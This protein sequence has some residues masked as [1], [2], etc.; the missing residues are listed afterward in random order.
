MRAVVALL[1]CGTL[2][3]AGKGRKAA[4]EPEPEPEP[5]VEPEPAAVPEPTAL[6]SA[7]LP[8]EIGDLPHGLANLSAQGCNA[9]HFAAHES[10]SSSTH[11]TGHASS[12]FVAAVADLGTPACTVCHLPIASQQPDLLVF[13]ADDINRPVGRI[14]PSWNATLRTE[15]VTCAAC[16]VRDGLVIGA[17]PATGAAPHPIGWSPELRDSKICATCHQ[18]TWP[19]ANEPLYDT[20]GE[21]ERSPQAAAGISC[22]D[23][24]MGP[25]ASASQRRANHAF[26]ARAGR[27]VSVLIDMSPEKI[28]R[29]D[30]AITA[31]IRLQ[32]TGAG[33][34][35]P[36]GSPFRGIRVEIYLESGRGEKAIRAAAIQFDLARTLEDEA[37]WSTV[38]DTRLAPGEERRIDWE[39]TLDHDAPVGPWFLV[40]TATE[41]VLGEVVGVPVVERRIP[42]RVE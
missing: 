30:N 7:P 12:R 31:V 37:P 8:V 26:S 3:H 9:C 18:L 27:G 22:Q 23:C 34:A 42:V 17:E 39:G 24:H 21:W 32:N 10:W 16:H 14:N 28:V 1:F 6:F 36:T 41:T 35:W 13:D 40:V 20:Y 25:G 2:A 15:G 19:G 5:V 4:P 38:A 33:H 29:G 11:A